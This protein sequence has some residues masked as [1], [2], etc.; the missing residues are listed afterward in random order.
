MEQIEIHCAGMLPQDLDNSQVKTQ[1]F[2]QAILCKESEDV[3]IQ[4]FVNT[5]KD[6]IVCGSLQYINV[7]Q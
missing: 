2:F 5:F 1:L 4:R 3:K 7:K 6:Y